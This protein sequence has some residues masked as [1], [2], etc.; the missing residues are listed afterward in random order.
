MSRQPNRRPPRRPPLR[1][2]RIR[3]PPPR[4]RKS[5][6]PRLRYV[7]K[8]NGEVDQPLFES[9]EMSFIIFSSGLILTYIPSNPDDHLLSV[10]ADAKKAEEKAAKAAAKE[11]AAAQKVRRIRTPRM[12]IL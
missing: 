8:N 10:Q 2:P 1:R 7:L 4:R 5:S 9:E 11:K 3:K 6:R 12:P